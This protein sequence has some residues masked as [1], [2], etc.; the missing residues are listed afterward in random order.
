ME[1][2][3]AYFDETGDD[4]VTTASSTHFVLTSIYMPASKWQENYNKVKALR[5]TLRDK[6]GFH[7]SEEMHTK[8]FLT[9]KNPYRTYGWSKEVKQEILKAFTL[10]LAEMELQIINVVIDKNHIKN[11]EYPVLE[12]ALTYNI[13]RIEN[14]SAG[15][16]NYLII[17]DQG[18]IAPM[19]KTAR[20]IRAFNPIQSKYSYGFSNQPIA[21]LLEDILEKDSSESYFI[22]LADFISYFVH[23]YYVV[24]YEHKDLPNRVKNV[25]DPTFIRRVMNTL[26]KSERLNLKAS[27][28]NEFG[29]V[30]YPKA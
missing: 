25:I 9:D 1:T 17:T 19:R 12:N 7:V 24:C 4:G 10:T 6:Y 29:L 21:N 28:K 14:D 20:A 30:I 27:E 22:Q 13:Q 8:H 2:Y 23:L 18:R 16:W 3:I 26:K 15:E 5:K 11:D